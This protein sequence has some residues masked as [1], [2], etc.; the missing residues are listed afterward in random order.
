MQWMVQDGFSIL[1]P[2]EDAVEVFGERIKLSRIV[3]VPQ[4]NLR[5]WLILNLSSQPNKVTP[6]FNDTTDR[7]IALEAMQ[8]GKSLLRILQAIWEAD[9]A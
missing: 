3:V 9:P 1:L 7:E 8:F 5:P 4:Y 2:A 6:S